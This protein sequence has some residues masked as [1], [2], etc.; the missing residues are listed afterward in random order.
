MATKH[1]T[2]SAKQTSHASCGM[3]HPWMVCLPLAEKDGS[4]L[5]VHFD[6]GLGEPVH[7]GWT[8]KEAFI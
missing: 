3:S 6:P 5:G 1:V 4:I 8:E 2:L 7:A